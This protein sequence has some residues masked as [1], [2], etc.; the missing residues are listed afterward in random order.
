MRFVCRSLLLPMTIPTSEK[1]VTDDF[2]G[3]VPNNPEIET[4]DTSRPER[5]PWFRVM[6]RP[7]HLKI[8]HRCSACSPYPAAVP[9]FRTIQNHQ[10][11]V[12]LSF[13]V[14]EAVGTFPERKSS[15]KLLYC[16]VFHCQT[17]H[18]CTFLSCFRQCKDASL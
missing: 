15:R 13:L 16:P 2:L 17:T 7:S 14:S 11:G 3:N 18:N 5:R 10:H 9:V 4:V 1:P 6:S 12:D 8:G